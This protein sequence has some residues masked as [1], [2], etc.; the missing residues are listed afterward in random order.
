MASTEPAKTSGR[1]KS[2]YDWNIL[3]LNQL[4]IGNYY[5]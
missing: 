4:V 2:R 1:G 3:Y 5:V